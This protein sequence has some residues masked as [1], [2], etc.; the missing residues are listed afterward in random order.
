[1]P[2]IDELISYTRCSTMGSPKENDDDAIKLTPPTSKVM[3][4]MPEPEVM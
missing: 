4:S 3:G 1:M 2:G